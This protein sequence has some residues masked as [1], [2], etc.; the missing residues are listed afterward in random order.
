MWF[1]ICY[2]LL[3]PAHAGVALWMFQVKF[4]RNYATSIRILV[5][6]LILI[7]ILQIERALRRRVKSL[8]FGVSPK[9]K[10]P[11]GEEP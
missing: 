7:F 1:P 11:F 5:D 8:G 9:F 3:R 4:G 2:I 10:K 6:T